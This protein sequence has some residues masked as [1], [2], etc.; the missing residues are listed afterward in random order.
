MVVTS[1]MWKSLDRFHFFQSFLWKD[2]IAW[3]TATRKFVHNPIS[4]QMWPLACAILLTTIL[5]FVPT[6]SIIALQLFGLIQVPL[7][8]LMVNLIIMAL[9]GFCIVGDCVFV[10]VAG[11]VAQLFSFFKGY[12]FQLRSSKRKHF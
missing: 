10:F 8:S 3:D 1:L 4:I 2:N 11:F 6:F 7:S 9:S 5:G 12:E